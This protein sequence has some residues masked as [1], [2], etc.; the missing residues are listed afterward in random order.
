VR[1]L[2]LRDF[3]LAYIVLLFACSGPRSCA[4]QVFVICT[5]EQA[6]PLVNVEMANAVLSTHPLAMPILAI[7]VAILAFFVK[8]GSAVF[9]TANGALGQVR[10]HDLQGSVA[11][12]VD[13]FTFRLLAHT[14]R[15]AAAPAGG[16]GVTPA[17]YGQRLT[18]EEF[19][20][21]MHLGSRKVSRLDKSVPFY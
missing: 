20:E 7:E 4:K 14:S 5:P 13:D 17:V 19:S 12:R 10:F 8:P 18:N 6:L 15:L 21:C 1:Q 2:T 3:L 9:N 11:A 16:G